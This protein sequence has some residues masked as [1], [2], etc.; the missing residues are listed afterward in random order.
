M[1]VLVT[2][3]NGFIGNYVVQQLLKRGVT[4]IATS[5]DLARAKEKDWFDKVQF[6]EYD[7]YDTNSG[8]LFKKFNSPDKMIHLG[9]GHLANFKSEEHITKE[10]P[11]QKNFL[12][13]L[14]SNGLK[15]LTV[16]GTCLEYGMREGCLREDMPSEPSIAYPIAKNK[17]RLEL[18]ALKN[19]TPFNFKWVRLFYMYGTGQSE[20]SIIPLLQ[21]ALAANE[22][23]FNMSKGDQMRDYLDVTTISEN[24]V[25]FAMQQKVEGIINCSSNNPISIKELVENYLKEHNK[26]I[27][28][29]LGFYPYPDYEPMKFWGDNTKQ[30]NIIKDES[31]RTI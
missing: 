27:N 25:I 4:V 16:I 11:A 29:N 28:L 14:I 22:P 24:I 18:E 17:L 8:D 26:H 23:T 15:D 20:K 7:M 3:A 9:W 10:L 31:G 1:K 13:N 2:G 12:E 5:N 6:V 19:K 30:L 21:K